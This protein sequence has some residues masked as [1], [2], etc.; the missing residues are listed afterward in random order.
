MVQEIEPTLLPNE[1][2]GVHCTHGKNRT[3]Y[4]IINY[5]CKVKGV[6]FEEALAAFEE[7]RNQ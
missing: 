5:M 7:S 2:I 3:G 1:Y 6:K 4:M